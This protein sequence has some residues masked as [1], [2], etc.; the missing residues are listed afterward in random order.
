VL[1][2]APFASLHRCGPAADDPALQYQATTSPDR[3]RRG[4]RCTPP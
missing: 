2:Q 4:G 3:R 1:E